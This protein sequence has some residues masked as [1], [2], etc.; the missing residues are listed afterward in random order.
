MVNK[1]LP[2]IQ[3][4]RTKWDYDTITEK[5]EITVSGETLKECQEYLE[6]NKKNG[7]QT[8][9]KSKRCSTRI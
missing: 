6:K 5:E 1:N 3:V 2:Y 9:S 7:N 4:I 8:N